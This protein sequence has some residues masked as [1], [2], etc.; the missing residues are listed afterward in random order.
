MREIRVF[1]RSTKKKKANGCFK[2][3]KVKGMQAYYIFDIQVLLSI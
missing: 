3:G 1:I 2:L